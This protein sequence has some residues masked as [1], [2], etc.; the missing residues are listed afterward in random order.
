MSW[1][2]GRL[3]GAAGIAIEGELTANASSGLLAGFSP[4]LEAGVGKAT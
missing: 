3:S 1:Q 4:L 2:C